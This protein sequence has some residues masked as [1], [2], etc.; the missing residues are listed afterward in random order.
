MF[1][2][3]RGIIAALCL[4]VCLPLAAVSLQDQNTVLVRTGTVEITTS[5]DGT[6]TL[7]TIDVQNGSNPP[8]G[9]VDHAFRLQHEL[10]SP[11]SYR[12]PARVVFKKD[13][14]VV[15]IDGQTGFVFDV[16][17]HETP[18]D[19]AL[20]SYTY[21]TV[22]GLSHF[23]GYAAPKSHADLA[24]SLLNGGCSPDSP[25]SDCDPCAAG[26]PGESWCAAL[27]GGDGD[28]S[29]SCG[30]GYYACCNCPRSC[31][32]CPPKPGLH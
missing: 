7:V 4:F 20:L 16:L 15:A 27:C 18:P 29:A 23:W 31:G 1:D 32:C 11:L 14:L 12:G 3:R 6:R 25:S 24:A 8:D 9:Q 13:R 10:M 2:R 17:G 28:C 22:H 30:S 19:G 5:S 26:G 21:Y